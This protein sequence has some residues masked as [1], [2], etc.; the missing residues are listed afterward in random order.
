MIKFL[1]F[2]CH[3]TETVEGFRRVPQQPAKHPGPLMLADRPWEN[4]NMQLYGSVAR[5]AGG[6]FQLWY[7]V[8][9]PPWK[10]LLAYAESEDGLHW[11]KPEL[12]IFEHEGRKTNIV[13]ARDPHGPAVICDEQDPRESWRYKMLCGAGPSHA[14]CAFRSADGIHWEAVRRFPVLPTNPDCPMGLLR[15]PDGRFAAL[16]RVDGYG[17]RVFRSESWD[18]V[19]WSGEPRMI[20][21]PDAGDPPQ[22][23]F[24]GMGATAYGCYEVGTLWIYRTEPEDTGI[25]KMR[26]IQFPEL[27]YARGGYAWH[28]AAQGVP[29]IPNG[30]GGDWD[31]G[32]LQCA[33]APLFLPGEIRFYYAGTTARHQDSW[34]LQPQLAGLGMASLKP[35]RF[36]ALEAADEEAEMLTVAFRTEGTRLCVNA[37][38]AADG[39]VRVELMDRA[40]QPLPGHSLEECLPLSGDGTEMPVTWKGGEGTLPPP[41]ALIRLRVRARRAQVFS[42]SCCVPEEAGRYWLFRAPLL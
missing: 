30:Q 6:P 29:F 14:I 36:V 8:V 41:G 18:F 37:K 5:P 27:V 26:G 33:S 31:R 40:A 2:D 20:L 13:L 10:M 35:D 1:F 12:D 9:Q 15:T 17:R 22:T 32:N 21:E 25:G 11:R 16:H 42:L 23:Q 28:R 7:T 38:T 34:E 24:Y 3:E 4:N 39:W 19:H